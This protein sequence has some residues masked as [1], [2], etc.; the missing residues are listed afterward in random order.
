MRTQSEPD[1]GD[2]QLAQRE[3]RKES[4]PLVQIGERHIPRLTDKCHESRVEFE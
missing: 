1:L 4:F 2:S 3:R